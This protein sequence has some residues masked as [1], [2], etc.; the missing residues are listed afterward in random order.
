MCAQVR[1][2]PGLGAEEGETGEEGSWEQAAWTDQSRREET[3]NGCLME[4]CWLAGWLA[5]RMGPNFPLPLLVID[6]TLCRRDK[7]LNPPRGQFQGRDGRSVPE[8][9]GPPFPAT[10]P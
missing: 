9:V 2:S 10:S 3:A 1:V 8:Q 4:T 7:K 5:G 6:T